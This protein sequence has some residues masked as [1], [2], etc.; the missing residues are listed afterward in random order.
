[1]KLDPKT[2]VTVC[3]RCFRACCWQGEFM[4]DEARTA[5]TIKKTIKELRANNYGEHESYWSRP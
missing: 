3:D 1:M 5:G 2:F 4:C